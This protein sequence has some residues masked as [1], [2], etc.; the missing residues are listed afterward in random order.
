MASIIS[1]GTTSG[2]ALNMTADTSG[3]LQLA[4]GATPTTAVTIDTS[5]R[6]GIGTASPSNKLDIQTSASTIVRLTG[7]NATNQGSGY[8]IANTAQTQTLLAL[9]DDAQINGGTPE[10]LMSI[11]STKPLLFYSNGAERMRIDSSGNLGIG[12]SG[13]NNG[14]TSILFGGATANAIE[15]QD[16][17]TNS[18]AGFL[19]CRNSSGTQIGSITRVSTTNAVAFNTTSDERLKSNIANTEP[20]LDKLM[21]IKVRQFDWTDGNLHQDAGFIAQ[22]LAPILSGIV[23]EGKT[24]DDVWQ[25]DYSRLTPYLTKAIQE[26]KEII[27]AQS[28][29]INNLKARIETLESK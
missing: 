24:E 5:Q 18:G 11:Y 17:G 1:A 4:T 16:S 20:V 7:G 3:Q 29:T 22:E 28:V 8:F 12:T 15:A 25:L 6:V 9:S 27:D 10:T 19:S 2:T 13:I 14:K 23:T 26:M 21:T